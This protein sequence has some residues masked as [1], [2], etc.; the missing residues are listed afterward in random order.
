MKKRALIFS[1]AVAL[2]ALGAQAAVEKSVPVSAQK[3]L[4]MTIYNGGRA[5][6]NDV[7]QV[8]LKEG[9]NLLSFVDIS[10]LVMPSSVLFKSNGVQVLEQNFNFDLL[11]KENLMEKS[12]G[13]TVNVEYIDPATGVITADKAELLAYGY[14]GPILK[15]G[16]K[17]ESSYP[18]RI[19]FNRIPENLSAR[20]TLIFDVEASQSASQD[21]E[22]SYLTNGIS[23]EA[24]YVVEL[25]KDDLLDINGLVTLTNN[26][27]VSYKN[28][29]L[30]LVAGDVNMIVQSRKRKGFVEADGNAVLLAQAIREPEVESISGYYLYTI[31]R[32]TNI[33]SKQTKQVA[34]LSGSG[35]QAK[36][37]YEY[38][39]PLNYF[40]D[41]EFEK[42]K[43]TM[44]LTFKNTKNNGL[45]QA[46]PKGTVRVYEK[47]SKDGLIFVGEDSINHTAKGQD[48]RLLL[49]K[50]F[51][52]TAKGKRV[53]F[54]KIDAKI[55][56]AE[57]EIKISNAKTT[58]VKVLFYQYLPNGWTILSESMKSQKETSNKIYWDVSVPEQGDV[59]LTFKVQVTN[60]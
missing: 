52:I 31:G 2:I 29:Q 54:K 34:L 10:D 14:G 58:P 15:I 60:Q 43:P 51:D 55:S 13:Q 56:Q 1:V 36:R 37:S 3:N 20:P 28:A 16:N 25:N 11:T 46:L 40:S 21:V 39:S 7:R 41:Y 17:I 45:G 30:Q 22:V 48:V 24:D 18:G 9:Q 26:T 38:E 44:Y 19:I 49:G 59:I 33:L 42:A 12:V 6:I 23:W 8:D 35:I 32:P 50:D 57:F 5:L 4:T 27:E 53:S 47:D